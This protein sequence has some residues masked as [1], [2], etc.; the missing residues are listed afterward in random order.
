MAKVKINSLSR[1]E[2]KFIVENFLELVLRLRGKKQ[3]MDVLL[4]LMTPSEA[5][6]FA[7]R[8]QVAKALLESEETQDALRRKLKVGFR[9]MEKIEQWLHTENTVRD[10]WLAKELL[11]LPQEPRARRALQEKSPLDKYPEHRMMKEIFR[12]LYD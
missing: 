6:M 4:R 9:T 7:R 3:V 2:R 11:R 1:T 12:S 10:K 8:I 5:L